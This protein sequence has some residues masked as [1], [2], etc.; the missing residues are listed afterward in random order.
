MPDSLEL[1]GV[2]RAVVPLVSAG[3]A[4]VSELV[5]DWLP[6]LPAIVRALYQLPEP[7][8]GLRGIEPMRVSRGSLE[9]VDLPA[10]EVG[11]VDVP[12]LTFGVR[13]QNERPLA[14]ANQ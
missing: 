9:V 14:C 8:A 12:T 6:R 7:T 10:A 2:R 5:T 1:P 11:A 13:R 3:D 4:V